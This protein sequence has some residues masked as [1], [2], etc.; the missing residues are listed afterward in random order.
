MFCFFPQT[1]NSFPMFRFLCVSF[2]DIVQTSVKINNFI[3]KDP[4]V[5]IVDNISLYRNLRGGI[6]IQNDVLPD[7]LAHFGI[8]PVGQKLTAGKSMILPGVKASGLGNIVQ[9]GGGP[10]H[11]GVEMSVLTDQIVR[12]V[13]GHPANLH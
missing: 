5:G 9:Q 13:G 7:K 4:F 6:L 8:T 1:V 2:Q 10:D 11:F 12:K 3:V